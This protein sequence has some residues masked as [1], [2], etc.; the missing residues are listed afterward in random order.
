MS[1]RNIIT[2]FIFL[3]TAAS[4][5]H[6]SAQSKLKIPPAQAKE[7][8]QPAAPK[9][10]VGIVVDQMRYDYLFRF[11]EKYQDGGFKR[12]LR[13]GF[14]FENANYNYVPTY[15][16]PGH[17]CIY[18]G[19]TPSHNGIISNDWYDRAL[20]KSI[21]CVGDSTVSPVGTTSISGKMSPRNLLTTTIT[22]ELRTATNFRSKVIGIA[23]KDRGAILPAGHT[24]TGAYWHD[25][26]TNNWVTSTY[27]MSE[28]PEW[29]KS[30]NALKIADSLLS[31][32]WTTILPLESYTESTTDDTP[33][34]GLFRGETKPVFPH[35]L[36][37]IKKVDEELIRKTPFGNTFTAAFAKAAVEGEQLGKGSGTDFLAISFSSTDY[38]GHMY[39][40]NAIELEDTYIRLD[41]ELADL[42]NFLDDK[43]GKNK[44]LLFLSADHGAAANPIYNHDHHL[45]GEDFDSDTMFKQL[46][47]FLNGMYGP[48]EYIS[49][50]NAHQV[51]LNRTLLESKNMN[52]KEMRDQCAKFI[53]QFEG[54]AEVSTSDE[55]QRESSRAGIFSFMQNGYHDKRSADVLI[56]LKPGWIDWYTKTGTT[57]GSA[58]SYD[59]HVP[60][61][62]FGAGITHGQSNASITVSDIAPTVAGM[63]N[64]ENPSG[65]TGK[66]LK[67]ILK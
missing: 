15:T 5:L 50:S 56:E 36:P 2:G 51:Y 46:K 16:A 62:F 4:A 66:Q 9:L 37:E 64:I 61:I 14:L 27:Y 22:D 57:H 3:Y 52:A 26:Y 34:E 35:N 18:T 32:P 55:M 60:V 41:R 49:Y 40:I 59:T 45:P 33:Y 19:T 30:F 29:A 25:P 42:L 38:V 63:L 39:G 23:L 7:A 17:A 10:V 11:S 43:I 20:G 8:A 28:L 44:Y 48:G 1:K 6:A 24:P 47:V 53:R 67:E 31:Q 13:E 65:T 58:Y 12:L 21:N 54:V